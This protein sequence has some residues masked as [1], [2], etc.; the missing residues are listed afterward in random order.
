MALKSWDLDFVGVLVSDEH[1]FINAANTPQAYVN[2]ISTRPSD[3]PIHIDQVAV[4][5]EGLANHGFEDDPSLTDQERQKCVADF[6]HEYIL[7][8]KVDMDKKLTKD[9][10]FK[11][12]YTATE[13]RVKKKNDSFKLTDKLT[14][15]PIFTRNE[16]MRSQIDFEKSLV[17]KKYISTSAKI[18]KEE[19]DF[20]KRIIWNDGENGYYIYGQFDSFLSAYGGF[21]FNFSDYIH[22]LIMKD[23]WLQESYIDHDIVFVPVEWMSEL[24]ED[25]VNYGRIVE[26]EENEHQSPEEKKVAIDASSK[27]RRLMDKFIAGSQRNGLFYD[28]GDLYNF[29]TSLKTNSLVILSGMSGT[30]KSRI[31]HEYKN[32][33]GLPEGNILFI[34]VRPFWQDDADVIGYLDTLNNIYRADDTGFINFLIEADNDKDNLYI[35]CFDEMNL[36]RVEHYFSQFLSVLEMENRKLKLYNEESKNRIHNSHVYD[37]EVPIGKNVFFIGTVNTDESTYHFSDKVLDRSNVINLKMIPFNEILVQDEKNIEKD[38]PVAMKIDFN[39][40]SQFTSNRHK[41]IDLSKLELDFFWEL[42]ELLSQCNKN[43]GVGWRIVR[44]IDRYLKNLPSFSPFNRK[45]ALDIQVVQRV[46]TK[47]RGSE[48]Q[49][50]GLLGGYN[51]ETDEVSNS[52]LM[53]LFDRYN[54]LSDFEHTK[55][56][57]IEKSRELQTH[58]YAI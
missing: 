41:T 52:E 23:E 26:V 3:F 55:K 10:N 16:K 4:F 57:V 7:I 40:F 35:V 12:V 19:R 24:D 38:Q 15:I 37:H 30:G 43:I 6:L 31:V 42:H 46:M 48:E 8:F 33:L 27:E 58:G 22:R 9:N 5:K 49:L 29:H 2:I 50:L 56:I 1:V 25:L 44:Q 54:S 36:A 53:Q 14:M 28:K 34:P 17:N 20:P 47:I 11:E 51:V 18:S 13:I 39:D 32:A 45:E 21:K